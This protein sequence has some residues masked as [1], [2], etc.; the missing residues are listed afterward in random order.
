MDKIAMVE[1]LR[2]RTGL[3]YEEAR[4]T[5]EG[6]NWDLLDTLV[7]LE[8]EGKI[9]EGSFSTQTE[10]GE[11]YTSYAKQAD[12]KAGKDGWQNFWNW[13]KRMFHKGNT[14]H[15]QVRRDDVDKLTIPVTLF[16]LLLVFAFHIVIPMLIVGLFFRMHY[17]FI[18]DDL[19][20]DTINEGFEKAAQ[21]AES[22]KEEFREEK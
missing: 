10:E 8:K 7:K 17:R 18:G 6:S 22:V 3:S 4:E 12:E 20:K 9:Q 19:G 21:A 11:E 2:K 13:C 16:V 14:N 1:D 5:L 15:F